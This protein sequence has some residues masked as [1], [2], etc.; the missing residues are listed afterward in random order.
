[1]GLRCGGS[2]SP[3]RTP[4][5]SPTLGTGAA[6]PPLRSWGPPLGTFPS[7]SVAAGHP[8][9]SQM[10][11]LVLGIDKSPA[12]AD[13][14][15]VPGCPQLCPASVAGSPVCTGPTSAAGL[16]SA[17]SSSGVPSSAPIG[18]PNIASPPEQ[19]E[20]KPVATLTR[21]DPQGPALV[22]RAMTPAFLLCLPCRGGW[23]PCSALASLVPCVEVS[24][25]GD[26]GHHECGNL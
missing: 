18:A 1:M 14:I 12:G 11:G 9:A 16:A 7:S 23:H 8:C 26:A 5:Q 17:C 22:G 19:D 13:V 3:W 6:F 2:Q 20:T 21:A 25:P 24:L 10:Q 15:Q 4:S